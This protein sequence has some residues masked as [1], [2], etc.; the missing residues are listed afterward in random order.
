[1]IENRSDTVWDQ[2]RYFVIT[3]DNTMD[4]A[5]RG[6][7]DTLGI[8]DNTI[9][10]EQIPSQLGGIDMGI[11]LTEG[12]DDFLTALRYA[13]P[14]DGG[15][16]GTRSN[17]WREDLP[18][19]VLRIR[20]TRPA[21]QTQ[22][23]PEV[24]FETRTGTTPPEIALASDLMTLAGAVC[25][26]WGQACEP[27]ALLNMKASPLKWTGPECVKVGMN[28]LAPNEDAAYFMGAKLPLPEDRV[29]ALV[30][31]LGT[32]TGNATYVGLG[33]NSSVTQL[34]F[35]NIDDD[36]LAGT[37]DSYEV[38]NHDR[39]FVQYFARDCA[40][41]GALTAGSHCYSVGDRLPYCY[42]P[43]DLSCAMLVFS[44]RDYLRPGTQRGPAPELTLSPRVITLQRP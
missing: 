8:P 42:N 7:L 39:F 13:M 36:M 29:Y 43:A 38:P 3:P 44:V 37:A 6:A 26:R 34:G 5:V 33:L 35:H 16:V 24:A 1:M 22:P 30:G 23:Y 9:F 32:R 12:S 41:L 19:V 18:L 15:A 25:S 10:T 21:H 40:G 27:K 20:D 17:A 31:A 11:G 28:C 2:L 14:D 4:L